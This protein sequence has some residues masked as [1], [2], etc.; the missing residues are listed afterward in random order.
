MSKRN[1][2]GD[3]VL[4]KKQ[5][6]LRFKRLV[7]VGL[8]NYLWL[9][10]VE[11]GGLTL[12]VKKNVAML[13]R[14]KR[15]TGILTMAQKGLLATSHSSRTIEERKKLCTIV[16]GLGCFAQ[17]PP[18][19]RARLVP[20]LHFM[21]LAEGRVLVKE[22]DD[23]IW[24]YFVI[25]GEIQMYR[26]V[27]N[28]V[29]RKYEA[30]LEAYIGPGDWIGDAELLD[31][32]L[33]MRTF[34]AATNCEILL[35][36]KNDFETLLMPH[37]K[38][39][40]IEKKKAIASLSYFKYMNDSQIV[41]AS[42][43]ATIRQYD[44]LET[45]Y[46]EEKD[47]THHVHFVLSGECVLLQCL[48]M[49]VNSVM[50]EVKYELPKVSEIDSDDVSDDDGPEL[51]DVRELLRSSTSLDEAAYKKKKAKR[52]SEFD[53]V[54][55]RCK[56]LDQ[57]PQVEKEQAIHH[58]HHHH[59]HHSISKPVI[60]ITNDRESRETDVLFEDYEEWLSDDDY[61]PMVSMRE[62]YS[63][64][65][66][67]SK[68]SKISQQYERKHS[69]MPRKT[70]SKSSQFKTLESEES[71]IFTA[72]SSRSSET[73]SI[74]TTLKAR[75]GTNYTTRF[76]DIGSMCYGGLFGVGEKSDH[77][78]IMARTTVQCLLLPRYWLMEDDQNPGHIWQRMRFYL[79]RYIPSRE[80][81]FQDFIKTR[82]WAQFKDE[83]V[84]PF[85]HSMTNPTK[86]EDI[87][88]FIRIVESKGSSHD[89][90]H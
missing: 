47:S 18:I 40:W 16:A 56:I 32:D 52:K 83:C 38:K 85:T 19:I 90:H 76:I 41:G 62:R 81:L 46:P 49:K 63:L 42:K 66:P 22:G 48:H 39:V 31:P 3:E 45:I 75:A 55:A 86:I 33:R 26:R 30:Q 60:N 4:R 10:E 15:K 11:D 78:V 9:S 50:G 82:K 89:V 36:E 5:A 7:R 64:Y 59:H 69:S 74:R 21:Q 14:R 53:R 8:A 28:K 1:K 20:Y 25:S 68:A 80:M 88:I 61:T 24:V 37:V 43:L 72:S 23:P 17:V 54:E 57:Q 51:F 77:R 79:E 84:E 27:F 35:L 44:P 29:T 6:K 12:N 2:E 58:H 87:P 13:V 67:S 65:R 70:A 34:K 73:L 71:E